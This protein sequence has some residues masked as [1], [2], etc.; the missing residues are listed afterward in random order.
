MNT[1]MT[2]IGASYAKQGFTFYGELRKY[3]LQL[4]AVMPRSN[5]YYL[6]GE[7]GDEVTFEQMHVVLDQLESNSTTKEIQ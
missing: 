2:F 6:S 3:L 7:E 5:I 4:R 1:V